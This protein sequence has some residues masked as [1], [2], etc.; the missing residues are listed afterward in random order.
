MYLLV[1]LIEPQR[2]TGGTKDF[3]FLCV[4]WD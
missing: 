3:N 2:T 4:L 1:N